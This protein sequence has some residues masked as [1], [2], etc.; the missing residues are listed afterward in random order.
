MPLI[1]FSV[2]FRLTIKIDSQ[3]DLRNPISIEF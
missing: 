1:G 3:N 2:G